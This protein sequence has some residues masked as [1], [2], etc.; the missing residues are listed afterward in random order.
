MLSFSVITE[1]ETPNTIIHSY[2]KDRGYTYVNIPVRLVKQCGIVS[3]QRF[4]AFVRSGKFVME[5]E[6]VTEQEV[7]NGSFV[8]LGSSAAK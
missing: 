7:E 1:M 6:K 2:T 5:Q 8:G 3:G 4:L